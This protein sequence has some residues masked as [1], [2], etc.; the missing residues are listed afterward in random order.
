LVWLLAIN[1]NSHTF[2]TIHF[3]GTMGMEGRRVIYGGLFA[4]LI[5]KVLTI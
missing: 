1:E 3:T 5:I 2:E 4:P